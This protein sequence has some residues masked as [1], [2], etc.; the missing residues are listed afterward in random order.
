MNTKPE[1]PPHPDSAGVKPGDDRELLMSYRARLAPPPPGF[2]SV[3]Q[4]EAGLASL[5]AQE[6]N[7]ISHPQGR[8]ILGMQAARDLLR[9]EAT[10]WADKFGDPN[11]TFAD[12]GMWARHREGYELAANFLDSKI[13]TLKEGA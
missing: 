9:A 2:D 13:T 12:C 3:E 4:F 10:I 6:A 11:A 7:P 5:I 1:T 8:L